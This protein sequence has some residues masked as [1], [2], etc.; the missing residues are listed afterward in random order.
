MAM[1]IYNN[2]FQLNKMTR[3]CFEYKTLYN[4]DQCRDLNTKIITGKTS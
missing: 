3:K 1:R 4:G 2:S